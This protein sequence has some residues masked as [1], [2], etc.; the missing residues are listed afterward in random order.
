MPRFEPMRRT[1]RIMLQAEVHVML[2]AHAFA[3]PGLD[4]MGRYQQF[5]NLTL[6]QGA[7]HEI[8]LAELKR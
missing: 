7:L 4:V 5:I 8:E 3:I 6:A 2:A 1:R